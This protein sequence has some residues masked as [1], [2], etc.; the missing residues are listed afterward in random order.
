MSDNLTLSQAKKSK[1]NEQPLTMDEY[2]EKCKIKYKVEQL[3]EQIL[4]QNIRK[5]STKFSRFS[6]NQWEAV[7]FFLFLA[8]STQLVICVAT[9]NH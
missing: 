7:I 4:E 5:G 2:I 8:R 3:K 9:L 6:S 1:H